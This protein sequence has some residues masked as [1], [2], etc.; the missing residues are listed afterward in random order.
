[1]SR[2]KAVMAVFILGALAG[3][4]AADDG[5]GV[6]SG[7]G[8]AQPIELVAP[9]NLHM[10]TPSH[11]QTDGGADVRL[12]PGWFL[13]EGSYGTLDT[14]VKRLQDAETRLKAE[15]GSLKKS[16]DGWQPG[17]YTLGVAVATGIV[18]GY[19]IEKHL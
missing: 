15:N 1:M 10:R 16:A 11:V 17:W 6:G 12:P 2:R 7:S 14:E 3:K 4:A 9:L 19:E 18:L 5:S 8:S 13:D